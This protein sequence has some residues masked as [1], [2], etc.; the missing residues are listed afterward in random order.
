MAGKVRLGGGQ[1]ATS[2][3][4]APKRTGLPV[5]ALFPAGAIIMHGFEKIRVGG[6]SCKGSPIA[7]GHLDSRPTTLSETVP[8]KVISTG[9]KAVII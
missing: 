8:V 9:H 5:S 6:I 4:M 2:Q 1:S 7:N 3:E